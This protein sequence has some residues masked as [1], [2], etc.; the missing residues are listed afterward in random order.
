MVNGLDLVLSAL[1]ALALPRDPDRSAVRLSPHSPAGPNADGS[2]VQA[3]IVKV[4][5]AARSRDD[6]GAHWR[7]NV[8]LI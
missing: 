4:A 2:L 3:A 1:G 5:G 7:I 6:A 8:C